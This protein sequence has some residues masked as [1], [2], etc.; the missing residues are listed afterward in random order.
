MCKPEQS[1]F[2]DDE[3]TVGDLL[4]EIAH[5]DLYSATNSLSDPSTYDLRYNNQI[6]SRLPFDTKLKSLDDRQ[7]NV[8]ILL[9]L[10]GSADRDF[11]TSSIFAYK[12]LVKAIDLYKDAPKRSADHHFV[13]CS[14]LE[15]AKLLLDAKLTGEKPAPETIKTISDLTDQIKARMDMI[16]FSLLVKPAVK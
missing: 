7:L 8:Y 3:M 11:R 1:V 6:L 2:V 13:Y 4:Y 16:I 15:A 5:N 12:S 9:K 10:G 14:I